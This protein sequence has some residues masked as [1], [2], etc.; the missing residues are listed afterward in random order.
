M[1]K[2]KKGQIRIYKTL[3]KTTKDPATQ[4]AH[5]KTGG[6]PRCSAMVSS[7]CSTSDA[8]RVTGENGNKK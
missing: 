5:K 3:H 6:E 7:S 8:R 4:T 1:T 2:K